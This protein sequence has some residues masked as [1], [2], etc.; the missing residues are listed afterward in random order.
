MCLVDAPLIL[1]GDGSRL[2]DPRRR[3]KVGCRYLQPLARNAGWEAGSAEVW[4][5]RVRV[6]RPG[7]QNP[8]GTGRRSSIYYSFRG[9]HVVL[10]RV[11]L[12]VPGTSTARQ[13]FR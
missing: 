12:V 4:T 8:T 5:L 13:V 3:I 7:G 11:V 9:P 10:A 2:E 6:A 1:A